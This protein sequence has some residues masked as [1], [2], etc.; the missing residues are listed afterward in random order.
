MIERSDESKVDPV[1][2]LPSV[3]HPPCVGVDWK[4][5]LGSAKRLCFLFTFFTGE[6]DGSC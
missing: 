4:N 5:K 3:S 6:T 1:L 2:V